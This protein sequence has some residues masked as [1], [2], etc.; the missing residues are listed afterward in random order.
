MN[1]IKLISVLICT[2]V[3]ISALAIVSNAKWWDDN[4]FTDVKSSHWYY[5]V[6]RITNENGIF[7]GTSEDK[8]A[9]SGKMTRAMLVQ[10]LA[11]ADGY[12]MDDYK[13]N[14]QFTDVK[15]S[16][17]FAPAVQWAYDNEITSGKTA[18]TFAPN[19]N[20]TREQLAAMLYRY[21]SYKG[22]EITNSK[23]I[24][25]FPD[26]GKVASYAVANF[27][28][29]YG[30]GIINGSKSGDTLYL[31]PRNP[32]T[33]A[34][35]ATMFSKYLYLTPTYEI[36]GNDL[37]LYTIVYSQSEAERVDTVSEAAELLQ[38]HIEMSTGIALPIVFD[39]QPV[40][41]YEI[42]VGKTNREDA[43]IVT[44]DRDAFASKNVVTSQV[45][46]N[47]LIVT[48]VDQD[49]HESREAMNL[50]GTFFAVH[51][52]L[53]EAFGVEIY[54]EEPTEEGYED[55]QK[56]NPDPVISLADGYEYTDEP[57]FDYR[58]FYMSGA[59]MGKGQCKDTESQNITNYLTG[60]F[61]SYEHN[62]EAT[63][64][65][66]NPQNVE[67][68]VNNI[69][70]CVD[71]DDASKVCLGINDSSDYCR[72][73]GAGGEGC[74]CD[75]LYN[76]YNSRGATFFNLANTVAKKLNE[77]YP[78][79]EVQIGAYTYAA[80]PPKNMT[81][82]PNITVEYITIE[83]CASHAYN[84]PT[85]KRNSDMMEEMLGW[86]ELTGGRI[87]FWDHSGAFMNFMTPFPDWDS[88]LTNV[89]IF[90]DH[91]FEESGILMN[92]V[93]GGKHPDFGDV[94]ALMFDAMYRDPYMTE[95]EYDY[96]LGKILEAYYGSGW[97][98]LREYIDI[99]TELGNDK[100]HS[101]HAN[102]A[103]WYDYDKVAAAADEIDALWAKAEAGA[104][105]AQ[106]N[107]LTLAKQS[108]IYLRQSATNTSKYVNGTEAERA[109][110]I[111]A[112]E[113]LY[114]YVT[115]NDVLW[116]EAVHGSLADCDM[117]KGPDK[118]Q[119]GG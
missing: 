16:H 19:E 79:I 4:P 115:Q 89:Q 95:K 82:E 61:G 94:R 43:G 60:D 118:W 68:I 108:W 37:S 36:N 73:R 25:A 20:I 103:G 74:I 114:D 33:R 63:P 56:Y 84:D 92:S 40:G 8:F 81:M 66:T 65:L 99:I 86:Y 111:A 110:Y 80:K 22:M 31:N 35:C 38:Y 101:F 44:V 34:E 113:A 3:I 45:Q 106:L 119:I 57:F 116:T 96:R 112:N 21:A 28:W 47:Y 54:A 88:Q 90:A 76:Q 39:D 9:P 14:G 49:K 52:L 78:G 6:V 91:S 97:K 23:D 107:R 17:W 48:G 100:C 72:G 5:D 70:K 83:G 77:K 1:K 51:Y 102:T 2:I 104:N 30:N 98:Y 42:L 117:T 53:E 75:Q 109:A 59:I 18:D 46:G 87:H 55:L 93:F 67:T 13:Y 62:Y 64:C 7:N 29:A 26:A 12:N 105:E 50:D 24:S 11:A 32:A 69:I 10:A 85:C 15:S 41:E 58:I 71:E 27:E